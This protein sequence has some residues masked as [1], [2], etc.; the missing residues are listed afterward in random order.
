MDQMLADAA[1]AALSGDEGGRLDSRRLGGRQ[2][3]RRSGGMSARRQPHRRHR[4]A[5]DGD[6]SNSGG[7][8]EED[9]RPTRA[10]GR[11]GS[12]PASNAAIS[13]GEAPGRSVDALVAL[14][15]SKLQQHTARR[16]QSALRDIM[17]K[18]RGCCNSGRPAPAL[19]VL[20]WRV[21]EGGV[22]A[23]GGSCAEA[24]LLMDLPAALPLV[25]FQS[26]SAPADVYAGWISWAQQQVERRGDD[27]CDGHVQRVLAEH[28]QALDARERLEARRAAARAV[29]VACCCQLCVWAVGVLLAQPWQPPPNGRASMPHA[30]M[31]VLDDPR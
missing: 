17:P 2:G 6:D 25:K 4:A 21:G 29:G 10:P 5:T 7:S 19:L 3:S 14:P 31:L 27:W 18:P 23:C 12:R 8:S 28:Q 11:S 1:D 13:E 22:C 9:G 30:S 16:L 24:R 20:G 26:H 15:L